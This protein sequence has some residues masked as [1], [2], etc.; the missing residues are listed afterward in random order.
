[1]KKRA[2]LSVLILAMGTGTA[3]AS[4]QA[5]VAGMRTD[6]QAIQQMTTT[7]PEIQAAAQS[8]GALAPYAAQEWAGQG[9]IIVTPLGGQELCHNTHWDQ[10]TS[11]LVTGGLNITGDAAVEAYALQTIAID[12]QQQYANL[13]IAEVQAHASNVQQLTQTEAQT[14]A[15]LNN[16]MNLLTVTGQQIQAAMGPGTTLRQIPFTNWQAGI[17]DVPNLAEAQYTAGP[18][19]GAPIGWYTQPTDNALARLIDRCP[20]GS[21]SLPMIPLAASVQGAANVSVQDE[22]DVQQAIAP[23]EQGS[24]YVLPSSGFA[25]GL[26]RLPNYP[27][28]MQ[29]VSILAADMPAIAAYMQPISPALQAFNTTVQSTMGEVDQNVQ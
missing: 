3:N 9:P 27:V 1:M 5:S 20:T 26:L 7:W 23:F 15:T 14:K 13:M 6:A 28:R 18:N 12:F 8:Y 16:L 19:D 11:G 29:I 22:P 2:L 21:G 17:G 24:S 4:I 25:S 10:V